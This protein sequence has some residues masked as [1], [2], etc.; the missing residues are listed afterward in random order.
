MRKIFGALSLSLA[1]V[2]GAAP[3]APTAA[4]ETVTLRMAN[5]LPTVHHLYKSMEEWIAEVD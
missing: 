1:L 5:W 3:T 4:A 2:V